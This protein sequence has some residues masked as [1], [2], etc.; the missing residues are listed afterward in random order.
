MNKNLKVSVILPFKDN[1]SNLKILLQSL[2]IQ[3][4]LP[5]EL[6]IIN[7]SNFDIVKYTNK[8]LNLFNIIIKNYYNFNNKIRAFPGQNRNLGVKYSSNEIIFFLDSKTLPNIHWIKQAKND[9]IFN[10]YE[11]ILGSTRYISNNFFQNIIHDLSYGNKSYESVPGTVIL[12]KSF[13]KTGEFY[14]TIRAGED[15]EWRKRAKTNLIYKINYKNSLSYNKIKSNFFEIIYVYF[16]YA[17]ANS[18]ILIYK[19]F[20]NRL[21]KLFFLILIIFLST[22]FILILNDIKLYLLNENILILPSMYIFFRGFYYPIFYRKVNF[23]KLIFFR[24]F[25]IGLVGFIL[26]F[27]KYMGYFIGLVA[28]LINQIINKKYNL[29]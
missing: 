15:I 23:K 26:D 5:H 19:T 21:S 7:A 18:N 13:Y 22:I 1:L 16:S 6:V 8:Y 24:W 2:S 20:K 4:E 9:L 28:N 3:E 10:K 29:I 14:N 17:Y 11:L 27:T 25:I 12:K